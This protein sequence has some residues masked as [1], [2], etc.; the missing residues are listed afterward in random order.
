MI[1]DL[2]CCF[3]VWP[4]SVVYLLFEG[5]YR[6]YSLHRFVAMLTVL[7]CFKMYQR[8]LE[9]CTEFQSWTFSTFR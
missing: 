3:S 7:V 9:T 2:I 4:N 6:I 8:Y 1:Y 5:Y